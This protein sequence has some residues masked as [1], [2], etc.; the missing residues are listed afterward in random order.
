MKG[1]K[2]LTFSTIIQKWYVEL[3]QKAIWFDDSDQLEYF[4]QKKIQ[5]ETA[6]EIYCM[7]DWHKKNQIRAEPKPK[8]K[9]LKNVIFHISFSCLSGVLVEK[10]AISEQFFQNV[11]D[12]VSGTKWGTKLKYKLFRFRKTDKKNFSQRTQKQIKRRNK[13]GIDE[14]VELKNR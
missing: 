1:R 13:N 3:K 14:K 6:L 2:K 7:I 8:E 5:M 11:L 10:F 4:S 9:T 12:S